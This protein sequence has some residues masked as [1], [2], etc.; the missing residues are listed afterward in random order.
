MALFGVLKSRNRDEQKL[1]VEINSSHS[2]QNSWLGAEHKFPCLTTRLRKLQISDP[3]SLIK[4]LKTSEIYGVRWDKAG[5]KMLNLE[6]NSFINYLL[7]IFSIIY[8]I[9]LLLSFFSVLGSWA[10]AFAFILF[11]YVPLGL[12]CDIIRCF[13]HPSFS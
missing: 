7:I 11:A 6:W 4:N 12:M 9:L 8:F 13:M 2:L 1:K 3:F 10:L 5:P